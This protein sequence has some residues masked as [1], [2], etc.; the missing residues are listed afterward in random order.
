MLRIIFCFLCLPLALSVS[1]QQ[2][3]RIGVVIGAANTSMVNADDAKANDNILKLVPTFGFQK[4]LDF[5][6]HWRFIGVGAQLMSSQFGQKYNFYGQAQQTR[7]N[8]IRPSLLIHFNT[9][10]KR[11][12]RFS[13]YIGGAYGMLNNYK[14]I[15]QIS[16][17]LTKAI[18]YTTF[19]NKEYTIADTSTINGT[20]S[21]GIY[22]KTDA[23]I[24]AALGLDFRFDKRWL[25]GL[26]ARADY[27]ME[28]L[29]NYDKVK[30]KFNIGTNV[31]S[32]DYEH[33]RNKPSKYDYQPL[34]SNVRA[35]STNL[36]MGLYIS[37]KYLLLS[38][39]VK[40]YERYG[41]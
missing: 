38:E 41:Y 33:W 34:Y 30:Q 20:I 7:L 5:A 28:K 9:N 18:T 40:E 24:I 19:S 31:Y 4:G 25:I 37:V 21:E 27:G 8:Y 12:I 23:S 2:G 14:E 35:S 1:A 17:P 26:H 13:G 3:A 29:E 10:P 39:A 16:N 15:S 6:Y 32:Y 36:A 11:D 22:Y